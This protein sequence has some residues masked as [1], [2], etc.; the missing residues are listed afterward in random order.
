M[1][2]NKKILGLLTLAGSLVGLATKNKASKFIGSGLAVI[3]GGILLYDLFK[4]EKTKIRK[5][6]EETEKT[7]RDS[8]IDPEKTEVLLSSFSETEFFPREILKGVYNNSTVPDESLKYNEKAYLSTLHVMKN[9]DKR[10]V[11][12]S[13]PLPPKSNKSVGPVEIRSYFRTFFDEFISDNHLEMKNYLNV[14]GVVVTSEDDI[15]YYSEIIKEED[16]TFHD[17]FDRIMEYQKSSKQPEGLNLQDGEKFIRVETYLNLEF[18]IYKPNTGK[19]GLELI[20]ATKLI[21][22]LITDHPIKSISGKEFTFNLNRVLFHPT[23]DYGVFYEIEDGRIKT[24][25]I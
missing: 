4:E 3:S 11:I 21:N 23:D 2:R 9:V 5:Q 13:I 17:Y 20:S 18:P 7:L 25:E 14:I 1:K 10:R 8:G 15:T 19:V 6:I 16:E 24:I 22:S 12:I